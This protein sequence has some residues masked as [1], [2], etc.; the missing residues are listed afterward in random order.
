MPLPVALSHVSLTYTPGAG[1]YLALVTQT[2]GTAGDPADGFE[3]AFAAVVETFATTANLLDVADAMLAATAAATFGQEAG[4]PALTALI[5]VALSVFQSL[6]SQVAAT[7]GA[8]HGAQGALTAAIAGV[9]AVLTGCT[10][11]PSLP[12]APAGGG[13]GGGGYP[14]ILLPP[15]LPPEPCDP[16]ADPNCDPLTGLTG[17]GGGGFGVPIFPIDAL[18]ASFK[19]IGPRRQAVAAATQSLREPV[20]VS[21]FVRKPQV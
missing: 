18:G 21:S 11:V 17:G 8:I 7:V 20:T 1:G 12:S 9:E 14:I 3:A 13:G 16:F 2:L 4:D 15:I 10:P 19:A 5:P 6:A